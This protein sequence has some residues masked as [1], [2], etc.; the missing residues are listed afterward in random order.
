LEMKSKICL[1]LVNNIQNNISLKSK[2]YYNKVVVDRMTINFY[3]IV[4]KIEFPQNCQTVKLVSSQLLQIVLAQIQNSQFTQNR[5]SLILDAA[6]FATTQVQF[7]KTTSSW[8]GSKINELGK[9][10]YITKTSK[11]YHRLQK[12]LTVKPVFTTTSEQ[13]PPFYND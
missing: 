1:I 6:H 5:K 13:R 11:M 10:L 12:F 3:L 9:C 7:L 2:Y 4:L 8:N